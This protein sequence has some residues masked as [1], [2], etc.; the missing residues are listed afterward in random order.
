MRL[1]AKMK[2]PIYTKYKPRERSYLME[3]KAEAEYQYYICEY[4]GDEIRVHKK[5]SEMTGGIAKIPLSLTKTETKY[6][7][8]CNKC[9]IPLMKEYE[10]GKR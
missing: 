4:C 10:E 9:V 5:K 7:M 8:L 3:T 6:M 1:E 2:K